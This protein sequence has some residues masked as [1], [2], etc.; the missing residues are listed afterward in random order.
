MLQ[1]CVNIGY[2]SPGQCSRRATVA[3]PSDISDSHSC[4]ESEDEESAVS[5]DDS[6]GSIDDII[7][8]MED[9]LSL[10]ERYPVLLNEKPPQSS[11]QGWHVPSL[12][13]LHQADSRANTL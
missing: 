4:T 1:P 13:A 8:T 10:M 3:G 9:G 12:H 11:L 7:T 2:N 6:D 5:D